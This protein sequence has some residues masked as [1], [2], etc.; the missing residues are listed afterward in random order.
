MG[1]N[2]IVDEE[3]VRELGLAV[4]RICCEIDERIRVAREYEQQRIN[5]KRDSH[6]GKWL[7]RKVAREYE[8]KSWIYRVKEEGNYINEV[9]RLGEELQQEYGVSELEAINILNGNNT[10]D[11]VAM[12]EKMR[13]G[14]PRPMDEQEIADDVIWE[15]EKEKRYNR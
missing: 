14:I 13:D 5:K 2:Y 9:R 4:E 8:A 1:R 3:Y 12:Y 10:A 6:K 15:Y 11:Y 7:T